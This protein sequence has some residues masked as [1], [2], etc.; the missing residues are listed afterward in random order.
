MEG[1]KACVSCYAIAAALF[2]TVTY[3][4]QILPPAGSRTSSAFYV[5]YFANQVTF[6]SSLYVL[7]TVLFL[8]ANVDDRRQ[9]NA[10][11]NGY[12]YD[13]NVADLNTFRRW[14]SIVFFVQNGVIVMYLSGLCAFV[15]AAFVKP[16]NQSLLPWSARYVSIALA[17]LAII[18]TYFSA[19]CISRRGDHWAG[20]EVIVQ[21]CC[22]GIG[23]R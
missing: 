15:A 1:L 18:I 8:T 2:A 20:H 19:T 9:I 22:N 14:S 3:A 23:E 16:D 17:V 11:V 21:P 13:D 4:A 6:L 10:G 12:I 5:F 7:A